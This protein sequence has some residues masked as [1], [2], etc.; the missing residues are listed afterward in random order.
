MS[1]RRNIAQCR[2]DVIREPEGDV[3]TDAGQSGTDGPNLLRQLVEPLVEIR[4][5]LRTSSLRRGGVGQQITVA[6]CDGRRGFSQRVQL[7]A[8]GGQHLEDGVLSGP[9]LVLHGAQF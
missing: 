4:R 7:V 9:I 3:V 6:C 2:V 1:T 5:V 8:E